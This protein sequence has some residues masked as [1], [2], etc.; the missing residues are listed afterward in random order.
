MRP[1]SIRTRCF[2]VLAAAL[3]LAA[4]DLAADELL[5]KDGRRLKGTVV[6][7]GEELVVTPEEGGAAVRVKKA[8]VVS[9]AAMSPSVKEF[10]TRLAK[11]EEQDARG[12]YELGMWARD[13]R[14]AKEADKEFQHVLKIDPF[15]EGAGNALNFVKKADGRWGPAADEP[16]IAIARPPKKNGDHPP[17]NERDAMIADLTN[18]GGM[19]GSEKDAVARDKAIEGLLVKVQQEPEQFVKLLHDGRDGK[20]LPE[21]ARRAIVELGRRSGDRRFMEELIFRSIY[22]VDPRVRLES[23]KALPALDEPAALRKLVDI[24]VSGGAAERETRNRAAIAIRRYGSVEGIRRL[25]NLMGIEIAG[26][27]PWDSKNQPRTKTPPLG[28]AEVKDFGIPS[29]ARPDVRDLYRA[30]AAL[31]TVTGTDLGVD[32]S[33][34]INWWK[35]SQAT[36]QFKD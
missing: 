15:H 35:T 14:L 7:E 36:F 17:K 4:A 19:L 12:H 18:L 2:F 23:A 11:L 1:M 13:H 5:L 22:D 34:W 27:N 29:T 16:E 6:E 21:P 25:I 24:A 8:D 31:V 30:Y 9:H 10:G 20:P 26:G 3:A 32:P 33:A 28:I